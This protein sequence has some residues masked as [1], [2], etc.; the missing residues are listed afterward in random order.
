MAKLNGEEVLVIE[1]DKDNK[2]T[3]VETSTGIKKWVNSSELETVPEEVKEV[4]KKSKKE[5]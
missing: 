1:S 2:I 5:K 3:Y 4:T